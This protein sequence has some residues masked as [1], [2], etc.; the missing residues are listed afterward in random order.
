MLGHVLDIYALISLTYASAF[1]W[2]STFLRI[3][4]GVVGMLLKSFIFILLN[5]SLISFSIVFM[6]KFKS[7]MLY[8]EL[9]LFADMF[10]WS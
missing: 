3:E 4:V 5:L 9:L 1:I 6:K 2:S 7:F 8:I 10:A